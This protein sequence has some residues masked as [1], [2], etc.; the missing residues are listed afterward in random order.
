V[1][2]ISKFTKPKLSDLILR[3]GKPPKIAPNLKK[4]LFAFFNFGIA[5]LERKNETTKFK[6]ENFII[7]N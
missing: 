2:E 5:N 4:S 7:C 6:N 1:R 3:L